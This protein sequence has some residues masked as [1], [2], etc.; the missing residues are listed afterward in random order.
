MAG[1]GAGTGNFEFFHI[2]DIIFIFVLIHMGGDNR[3]ASARNCRTTGDV[4]GA[5]S[6][7]TACIGRE[8]GGG[9]AG[10]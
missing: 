3:F 1:E 2:F 4:G 10:R 5:G 9:E 8:R 7:W 6:G